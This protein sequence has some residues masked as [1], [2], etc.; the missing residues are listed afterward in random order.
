MLLVACV[1]AHGFGSFQPLASVAH[2]QNPMVT[3]QWFLVVPISLFLA[4]RMTAR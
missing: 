3:G 2:W 4:Q 1:A